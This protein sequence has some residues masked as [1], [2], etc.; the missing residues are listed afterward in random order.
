[1][2]PRHQLA[3]YSP[4]SATAIAR[5]AVAAV[6]TGLGADPRDELIELLRHEYAATGVV[7]CGSGTQALQLAIAMTMRRVSSPTTVA[8]PGFSCFDVA[9]AAV[10]ADARVACYDIDPSTLAPDL[11]SLDRVIRAGAAVVVV[12]PLY[13]VPVPWQEIQSVVERHGALL[14]EDAAQGHGATWRGHA[15]GTLGSI[16]T[17]SFGR[18]KGWTG[19]AGGA[20]LLRDAFAEDAE[21]LVQPGWSR[22]VA[23]TAALAMQWTL[24]RPILYG[25]PRSVPGLGIGETH[26]RAPVRP[27]S[28]TR[29]AAAALL[30]T[31]G[32]SQA[33][34]LVRQANGAALLAAI[35]KSRDL[36]P[37]RLSTD[38]TPGY[39]RLPIV[40]R[41][42]AMGLKTNADLLRQGAAPSYPIALADLNALR[43]RLS[44]SS[45]RLVGARELAR[46]LITLP[47]HS[48]VGRAERDQL[49]SELSS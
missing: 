6:G 39:L 44:T 1:M 13:G 21:H 33:E 43:D 35:S 23:T 46:D 10:G 20:L 14:I 38:M 19:G 8:L 22:E 2:W 40:F 48:R 3:A 34:A 45:D 49:V 24:G 37:I 7:L 4:I 47:T 36:H 27:R 42:T 12:A 30:Q 16:S 18:G 29:A 26:Y 11:D 5:S 41:D 32:P 17:L 15:L 28:M 9:A 31:H 25:I